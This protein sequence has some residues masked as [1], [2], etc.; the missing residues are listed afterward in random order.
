MITQTFLKKFSTLVD[1]PESIDKVENLIL[2]LAVQGKLVPQEPSDEPVEDLLKRVELER[3]RLIKEG[4]LKKESQLEPI[5]GEE[6]PFSIPIGW[7][8]VRLGSIGKIFNGN[9]INSTD[10]ELNYTNLTDG[11]PYIATKD[12][13]YETRKIDYENGVKIPFGER[14]FRIARP[15]T[16]LICAEGGSAGKKIAI[17]DR[18]IA[19]GNKLYAIELFSDIVPDYI[20]YLYQSN[21]FFKKFSDE[22]TGIIGGISTNKFSNIPVPI[23]PVKEQ[24]RIAEK[25]KYLLNQCN[26]LAFTMTEKNKSAE[27]LNLFLLH[28]STSNASTTEWGRVKDNFDL[29]LNSSKSLSNLKMTILQWAICGRLYESNGLDSSTKELFEKLNINPKND[30]SS[31]LFKIP[32]HWAWCTLQDLVKETRSI[33]YGIIKLGNEPNEGV[34][35]LRCS[36]VRYRAIDLTNVRKVVPE[37]SDEYSRTLLQGGE[38]LINIRGTLGG[39]AIAPQELK[40][41]NIAREVAMVPLNGEI[42]PYYVL[43]VISS[44]YFQSLVNN[45]LR[46]IAYKGLNLSIL[47]EFYIPVPPRNEQDI[48]V[49]QVNKLLKMCEELDSLFQLRANLL[50]ELMGS[51]IHHLGS[52]II[53]MVRNTSSDEKLSLVSISKDYLQAATV[54][55]IVVNWRDSNTLGDIKITKTLFLLQEHCGIP[56]KLKFIKAAAGPFDKAL[57]SD[58]HKIGKEKQWFEVEKRST[59]GHQYKLSEKAQ[60]GYELGKSILSEN[61]SEVDA[62]IKLLGPLGSDHLEIIATL[63]AAWKELLQVKTSVFNDEILKEFYAWSEK[64]KSYPNDLVVKWLVWMKDYKLVPDLGVRELSSK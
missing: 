39:C 42:N 51:F 28:N 4:K 13:N 37:I 61:Q 19:F 53:S 3:K 52:N 44:P 38:L 22:K 17:N 55:Y 9:S 23:P 2:Q 6:I 7:Q 50:E 49:A 58:I 29:I 46:G 27:N 25:L 8:W 26:T 62:L 48:I 59:G 21:Y 14:G 24:R 54:T 5:K 47:R 43:N 16:V 57:Y 45:S 30:V 63:Y 20:F 56:L 33:S 18:E 1:T 12:I 64:K 32:T 35:V 34:P 60:E 41:Y 40:G 11:Y 15:K 31:L 36:D 10:K